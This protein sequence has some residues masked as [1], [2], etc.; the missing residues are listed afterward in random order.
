[1]IDMKEILL[2]KTFKEQQ[3][4]NELNF[5]V[6]NWFDNLY[7][8]EKYVEDSRNVFKH[9]ALYN[10]KKYDMY[11]NE[12]KFTLCLIPRDENLFSGD[13]DDI[14]TF[15]KNTDSMCLNIKKKSNNIYSDTN[16]NFEL[17]SFNE[18]VKCFCNYREFCDRDNEIYKSFL[19]SND[20]VYRFVNVHHISANDYWYKGI[21]KRSPYS[22][23]LK[24]FDSLDRNYSDKVYYDENSFDI[25]NSIIEM[26]DSDLNV[27]NIKVKKI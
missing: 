10:G 5:I 18:N 16:Y 20:G 17:E 19:N 13:F 8:D 9:A 15:T 24:I 1:M 3:Y 22:C 26:I 7:V 14:I 23:D 4:D 21:V 11:F 6:N 25:N 27:K 12:K 2:E